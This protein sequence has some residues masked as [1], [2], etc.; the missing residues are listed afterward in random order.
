[1]LLA[2]PT[3]RIPDRERLSRQQQT[4]RMFREHLLGMAM[5]ASLLEW[6]VPLVS[7]LAAELLSLVPAI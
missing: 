1:M 3:F 5:P 2:T 4:T 6:M 7:V